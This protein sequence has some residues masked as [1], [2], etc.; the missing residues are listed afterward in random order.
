MSLV[1]CH[2]INVLVQHA[3]PLLAVGLASTLRTVD[4]LHV[5]A[6]TFEPGS[7]S[8][9]P[10]DVVVTDYAGGVEMAVNQRLGTAGK[11]AHARVMIVA[12][13]V[14]ENDVRVA[15]ERGV[16]GYLLLGCALQELAA[17]VATLARGNRYLGVEVAQRMADSLTREALTVREFDVLRLLAGGACNKT[18]ARRLNIAIGT[19]KTHVKSIM[20]KLDAASRTQAV[21]IASHRGLVDAGGGTAFEN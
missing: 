15:L 1:E 17:G 11:L 19:V 3:E 16:H 6:P 12:A 2:R 4:G 5:I 14:R 13:Q 9:E 10:I 21:T 18:I 20:S 8:A 7:P